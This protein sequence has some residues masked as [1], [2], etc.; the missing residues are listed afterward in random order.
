MTGNAILR[1]HQYASPAWRVLLLSALT[2]FSSVGLTQAAGQAPG[3]QSAR[4]VRPAARPQLPSAR[5]TSESTVLSKQGRAYRIRVSSPRVPQP[6]RGFP[7]IYVLDGDAWFG[8]TAEVVRMREYSKL[9]P[10]IVVG[11][12]YPGA[13][14][15]DAQRRSFD[16]T[17]PRSVD[18]DMQEAGIALGGADLFLAFCN[19]TLKP[20][21]RERYAVDAGNQILFGHSL[22]GLFVLHA[23]FAAPQSFNTYVAASPSL[24]FSDKVVLSGERAFSANPARLPVR[25][26]V[27]AGEFEYPHPSP[28]QLEDYRRYFTANPALIEGQTAQQAVDA[29]F[30][31][32]EGDDDFDQAREAQALAERLAR[33][34]VAASFVQFAGEEHTS[35]A[36]SAV[37]RAVPFALRP[38]R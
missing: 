20:W 26:L 5:D 33:S 13:S 22:G 2:F 1:T 29:L 6:P 31:V 21:V 37:N 12:G 14:F 9:S 24:G 18:R 7:V 38:A 28:G 19:E 32:R 35:S 16:F 10:A 36:V 23:M 34:G 11:I 30:A 27:T 17:P 8:I 3:D 25:L 15:F 4:E